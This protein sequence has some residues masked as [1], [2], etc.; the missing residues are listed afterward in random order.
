MMILCRNLAYHNIHHD[1]DD[2]DVH[3]KKKGDNSLETYIKWLDMYNLLQIYFPH[4]NCKYKHVAHDKN[5][6]TL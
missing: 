3:I 5:L 1:A 2:N 4:N 6:F